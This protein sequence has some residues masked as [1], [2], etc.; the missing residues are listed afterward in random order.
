[1]ESTEFS[2]G[3]D[4]AKKYRQAEA[5]V[6][7]AGRKSGLRAEAEEYLSVLRK[8]PQYQQA[9]ELVMQT[10]WERFAAKVPEF[11]P[12]AWEE[13]GKVFSG[14]NNGVKAALLLEIGQGYGNY[15]PVEDVVDKFKELFA[16]TELLTAISEYKGPNRQVIRY[17]RESLCDVGLL[18][19]EVNDAGELIGFGLTKK[20]KEFGMPAA[21]LV[22]QRER[23]TGQSLYPIFGQ[24]STSKETRAPFNRTK[25]LDYLGRHP[26]GVREVDLITHLGLLDDSTKITLDQFRKFGLIKYKSITTKTE[27]SPLRYEITAG[28]DLSQAPHV[29]ENLG[30][31]QEIVK[32]IV[33]LAGSQTRQFSNPEIIDGLPE[34]LKKRWQDRSLRVA[35]PHIL[36]GLARQRWLTRVDDF[37]GGEKQ[38]DISLTLAGRKLLA[39]LIWPTLSVVS[40]MPLTPD[41]EKA[42]AEVRTNLPAFAQNSAQLYYPY[43][44]SSKIRRFAENKANAIGIL[45][46]STKPLTARVIAEQLGLSERTIRGYLRSKTPDSAVAIITVGG[47]DIRVSRKN[48]KG[49]WYYRIEDQSPNSSS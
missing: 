6:L 33:S 5:G 38:S 22:L 29:T 8:E 11:S 47:Q 26:R 44:Q 1:M 13:A 2:P 31:Q 28:Q 48:I 41:R 35:V 25:I 21:Y 46:T 17:C 4:Q 27:K 23:E 19:E 20:G 7:R 39:K 40:K 10:R 16:G 3:L 32:I 45:S 36:S 14:V 34:E 42:I 15:L 12:A 18:A 43:S 30:L 37:K 49:V 9:G 24:T